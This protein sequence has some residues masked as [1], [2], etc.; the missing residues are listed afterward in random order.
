M[1]RLLPL[2]LSTSAAA[3]PFL[4]MSDFSWAENL[5]IT[6]DGLNMFVS[7]HTRGDLYRVTLDKDGNQ[8]VRYDHVSDPNI[9]HFGGL[10]QSGNGDVIYA[11]V[12]FEDD[13]TAIIASAANSTDGAYDII[14]KTTYQPNGLQLDLVHNVFYYT[15]TASNSLM[16]LHCETECQEERVA[17]VSF[18]NGCWIDGE[19]NIMYVGEL[20]SKNVNVFDISK[21]NALFVEKFTGLGS[22]SMSHMLD[23][24]TL[25][26][27]THTSDLGSTLVLGADYQGKEIQQFTLNGDKDSEVA[28]SQQVLDEGDLLQIT[29]VRWGVSP[30]FDENS[31]YVS[32]GG[33]MSKLDKSRR[34]FQVKMN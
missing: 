16:S 11:G 28:V 24:L 12:T 13:S 25:Y 31:I 3:L 18:A 27:S 17:A 20:M 19:K 30:N 14:Y 9:A 4:D 21:E 6:S 26:S 23:D 1:N 34:V 29:S 8:Y 7:D 33:G 5:L 10:A 15:D 32:E 22:L 2:L